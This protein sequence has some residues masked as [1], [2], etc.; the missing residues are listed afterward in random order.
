ME[1]STDH[2]L[3]TLLL[4]GETGKTA[5]KLQDKMKRKNGN[6]EATARPFSYR[7]SQYTV[8]PGQT[9]VIAVVVDQS[10]FVSEEGMVDLA[11]E[12]FARTGEPPLTVKLDHKLVVN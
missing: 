4:Q 3:A 7:A 6:T 11:L 8:N 12:I 10:A 1:N 2:A 5:F 9:G